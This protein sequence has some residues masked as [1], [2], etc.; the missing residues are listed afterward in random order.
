MESWILTIGTRSDGGAGFN[1]GHIDDD[2]NTDAGV[3][4]QQGSDVGGDTG[5][6]V[7]VAGRLAR[8]LQGPSAGSGAIAWKACTITLG[9]TTLALAAMR[10]A[11]TVDSVAIVAFLTEGFVPVAITA[12]SWSS[13]TAD[14]V[15][16][17]RVPVTIVLGSRSH[18]AVSNSESLET[19][20]AN[21]WIGRECLVDTTAPVGQISIGQSVNGRGVGNNVRSIIAVELAADLERAKVG[22]SID[23]GDSN[24]VVVLGEGKV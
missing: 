6:I 18:D 4:G 10:A 16:K 21:G 8:R 7:C 9:V 24:Q 19:V 22:K 1:D 15:G 13:A 3:R 17:T 23:S 5:S 2:L 14:N 20:Y 12:T 11:I